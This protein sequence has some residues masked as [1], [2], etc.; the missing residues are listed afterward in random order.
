MDYLLEQ[1]VEGAEKRSLDPLAI[2]HEYGN[3]VR[4]VYLV[5]YR[6]FAGGAS[7][8]HYCEAAQKVT[9]SIRKYVVGLGLGSKM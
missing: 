4:N 1:A 9:P 3:D 6:Y 8:R 7:R 2:K 5:A